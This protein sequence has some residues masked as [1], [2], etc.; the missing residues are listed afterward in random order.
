MGKKLLALTAGIATLGIASVAFAFSPNDYS[1]FGDAAY[2]SPGNASARAV[3]LSSDTTG[4]FSGISY[5]VEDDVTFADLTTLSSDYQFESGSCIGG[6]PRFQIGIDTDGD[7]DRDANIFAYFGT[8]SGGAACDTS[9]AWANTGDFLE[10]GRLL[11]TS[12]LGGT[13]YDTYANALANY[14]AMS[15][16]GISLAEDSGWTGTEQVVNID[17][18]MI[19]DVTYTYEIPVATTRAECRDGGWQNVADADGNA[20]KNQGDCVSYVSTEGRNRAAG[21]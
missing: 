14:G 21:N 20:F 5:G 19:N 10:A 18:T 16:T 7:G 17:N 6:S 11:D 2:V 1:L 8:D 15:V 12:Q 4:T 3:Q 13:F 9:G